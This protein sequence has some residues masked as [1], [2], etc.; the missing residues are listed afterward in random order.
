M[1]VR[2]FKNA[3]V[4]RGERGDSKPFLLVGGERTDGILTG[5]EVKIGISAIS[6]RPRS[7]MGQNWGG[8]SVDESIEGGNKNTIHGEGINN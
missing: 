7:K 4:K 8:A 5:T 1:P 2:I 3:L 6:Q